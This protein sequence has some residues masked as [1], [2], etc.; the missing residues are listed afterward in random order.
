MITEISD[1]G[2]D[3]EQVIQAEG[4]RALFVLTDVADTA[5]IERLKGATHAA[6]GDAD[7]V[8]NHAVVFN[9]RP[10][11]DLTLEEWDH[12]RGGRQGDCPRCG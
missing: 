7:I 5:S 4:G 6:F 3:T 12:G 2:R 8:I 1:S 10:L 11:L 9:A